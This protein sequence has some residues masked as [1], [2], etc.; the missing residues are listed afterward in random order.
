MFLSYTSEVENVSEGYNYFFSNIENIVIIAGIL[1]VAIIIYIIWTIV[2]IG[3]LNDEIKKMS[4]RQKNENY[5][6]ISVLE[7]ILNETKNK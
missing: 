6:I 1:L 5:A 2:C 3:K 4:K 7:D